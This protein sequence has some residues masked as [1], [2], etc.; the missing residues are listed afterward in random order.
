MLTVIIKKSKYNLIIIISQKR[1]KLSLCLSQ[2]R[3]N[4]DEKIYPKNGIN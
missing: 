2:N 3:Q 4:F 1:H